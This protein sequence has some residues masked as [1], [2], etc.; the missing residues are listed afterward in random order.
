[1]DMKC[2]MFDLD[3]TLYDFDRAHAAAFQALTDRAGVLLGVPPERFRALYQDAMDE[4]ADRAWPESPGIHSRLIRCQILLEWLGLP[5]SHAP[6]LSR[7]YWSAFLDAVRPVPGVRECV[8]TLRRAGYRIGIGTNMTAMHQYEKLERLGLLD[9]L[10][11]IVTS[12][13][14]GA[15]K[16]DRRLYDL[17]VR[18]AGCPRE[19][20]VFVGDN[21]VHD[22]EGARNAGLRAVWYCPDPAVEADAPCI[23]S[24][25]E[26]P[27]LLASP[28]FWRSRG[29]CPQPDGEEARHGLL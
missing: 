23:R 12:E 13:E 24:L 11:F 7:T 18:K 27:D 17:C 14:A 21:P 1:M 25:S 5:L 4:Q 8:E 16:P 15:D 22:V 2:C 29:G 19:A 28:E 20:C 6:V 26:L 9:A 10:D 3:N